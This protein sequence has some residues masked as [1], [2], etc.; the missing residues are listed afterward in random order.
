MLAHDH[1]LAVRRDVAVPVRD[2]MPPVAEAVQTAL[3]RVL[4]ANGMSLVERR[5]VLAGALAL[6][7]AAPRGFEWNLWER[8]AAG[9]HDVLVR[10]ALGVVPSGPEAGASRT[11]ADAEVDAVLEQ[12]ERDW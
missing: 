4:E 11:P 12:L 8:D 2:G 7:L 6:E 3:C 10:W 9:V 1:P 5:S